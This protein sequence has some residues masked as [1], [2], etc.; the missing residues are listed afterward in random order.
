MNPL[1]RLLALAWLPT[2]LSSPALAEQ[3]AV[4]VEAVRYRGVSAAMWTEIEAQRPSFG[5]PNDCHA[6]IVAIPTAGGVTLSP[7]ADINAALKAN[8]LVFLSAGTYRLTRPIRLLAGK[9]LIGVAGQT[10][11]LDASAIA[12]AIYLDDYSVLVN[13]NVRDAIDIGLHHYNASRD[14]GSSNTLVYRVSVGRTGL[15]PAPN[16]NG[17]GFLL[18]QGASNN[19][20]VSTEAFDTWNEEGSASTAN[21]GNADGYRNSYGAHHNTFIDSHSYRNGDD[22]FDFWEGGVAFVYFST[23]NESGKTIGKSVTG[24]GNG[25]KLG[26]GSVRHY[27]YRATASNN[28]ANGFDLN[29][30]SVAPVLIKSEAIGNGELDYAGIA[31]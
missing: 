24:D 23:S 21:G 9:K 25:F 1:M 30:N 17:V 5:D 14:T 7:G 2:M 4:P 10:V 16:G 29:G 8:A 20:I 26:R 13:V 27:L 6:R 28:K 18:T 15:S 19:C 22:G 3:P 31:R 12:E 11:T